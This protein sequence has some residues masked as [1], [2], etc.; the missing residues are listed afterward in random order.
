MK[1]KIFIVFIVVAFACLPL[2]ALAYERNFPAGSIIIPMD[3][4][5]QPEADGGLLE[6]YGLAY[7][8]LGGEIQPQIKLACLEHVLTRSKGSGEAGLSGRAGVAE[9]G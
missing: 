5:Y 8:L 6:A 7:Y 4:F 2:K 1:T 3:T 9:T